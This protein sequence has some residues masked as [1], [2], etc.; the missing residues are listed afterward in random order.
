MKIA[1]S[2]LRKIIKE[3][4]SATQKKRLGSLKAKDEKTSEDEK[5]IKD[6]EDLEHQ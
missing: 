3:E 4:L 1:L 6:L 2:H 5:E